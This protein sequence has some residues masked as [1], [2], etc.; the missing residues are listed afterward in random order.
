MCELLGLAFNK[1]V[2]PGLSFRGFRHRARRN[3]HGWGLAAISPRKTTIHREPISA[4]QSDFA[5]DLPAR[6]P[7]RAPLFIGH[8]RDASR[9]GV[10]LAN[11]HPFSSALDDG[12]LV[13]AH[14]GT[15][16][17]SRLKRSVAA[18]F[19]PAGQ[20]DSELAMGALLTWVG[21]ERARRGRVPEGEPVVDPLSDYG[22][23]EEFLRHLNALGEM[24]LLFS[25]G[26]RLFCFHDVGGY[27]GLS[28]TR[29]QAPFGSVSLR[30]EDWEADLDGEKESGQAGYVVASRPLTDG[31]E[32]NPC[33][34]GR[35]LVIE[36]GRAVFGA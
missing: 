2:S 36:H 11:T 4:A 19:R 9:G 18:D 24:N 33:R 20:T 7:L 35:L 22:A 34:P 32:W 12:T 1:A 8:V 10:S 15:L 29:R 26:R 13:F 25:D 5:A 31:E 3:P 23:L 30:D 6:D 27:I 17:V 16:D 21:H 28:W 14:N